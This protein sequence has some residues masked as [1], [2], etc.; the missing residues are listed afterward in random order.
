MAPCLS[1]STLETDSEAGVTVLTLFG[2]MEVQD[3]ER[4]GET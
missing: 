3:D 1:Q 2:E 4:G